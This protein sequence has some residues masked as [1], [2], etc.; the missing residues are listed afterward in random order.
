MDFDR[1]YGPVPT[2]PSE[3]KQSAVLDRHTFEVSPELVRLGSGLGTGVA[4]LGLCAVVW[5]ALAVGF[6]M[7]VAM[8]AW[9]MVPVLGVF[10]ALHAIGTLMVGIKVLDRLRDDRHT[11]VTVTALTLELPDRILRF[12]EIQRLEGAG[13]DLAVR[14]TN[15]RRIRLGQMPGLEPVLRE[16]LARFVVERGSDATSER[17]RARV[18]GLRGTD[19]ATG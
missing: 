14:C 3:V 8:E 11:V 6:V 9:M 16:A 19:G 15:G 7:S 17:E 18:E 4:W 2:P 1:S 5:T 10:S 12:S 13:A